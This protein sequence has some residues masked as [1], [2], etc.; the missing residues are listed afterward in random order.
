[1][2]MNRTFTARVSLLLMP[3]LSRRSRP[4]EHSRRVEDQHCGRE[5]EETS[6]ILQG[7]VPRHV[8]SALHRRWA[9]PA[10]RGGVTSGRWRNVMGLP[11]NTARR[12]LPWVKSGKTTRSFSVRGLCHERTTVRQGNKVPSTNT[13]LGW[14]AFPVPTSRTQR[15]VT[16]GRDQGSRVLHLKRR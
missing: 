2:M 13:F 4:V 3:P 9:V 11:S 16:V 1:M 10:S 12:T 6:S 15:S 7:S 14:N 5:A 8:V